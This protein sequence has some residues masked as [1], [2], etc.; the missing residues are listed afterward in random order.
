MAIETTPDRVASVLAQLR[1]AVQ[2]AAAQQLTVLHQARQEH[3]HS[4]LLLPPDLA[5]DVLAPGSA[6]LKQTIEE[7]ILQQYG[8][9]GPTEDDTAGPAEQTALRDIVQYDLLSLEGR[10]LVFSSRLNNLQTSSTLS[11]QDARDLYD[12]LDVILDLEMH[13]LTESSFALTVH[14]EI[15]ERLPVAACIQH[16]DYIESRVDAL[17]KGLVPSKGKGLV[18]LRFCNELLRRLSKPSSRHTVFAGRILSFLSSVFPLGERSGVNLRGDFNVDNR[19]LIDEDVAEGTTSS[20]EPQEAAATAESTSDSAEAERG[21]RRLRSREAA[22]QAQRDKDAHLLQSAKSTAFYRLFW[23]AQQWFANP[24]VLLNEKLAAQ[25]DITIPS[26]AV[27]PAPEGAKDGMKRFRTVTRYILDVFGAVQR[28]EKEL[29]GQASSEE[30]RSAFQGAKREAESQPL[31]GRDLDIVGRKRPRKETDAANGSAPPS[32]DGEDDAYFPKYLTGK[33]LIEYELRDASFRRQVLVQHLILYQYLLS[34]SA[35]GREKAKGWKNAALAHTVSYALDES[36]DRWLRD[37]WREILGL[38]RDTS[39]EGR[40]YTLAALQILKHEARWIGWK[41]DS[42]PPIDRPAMNDEQIKSFT[43]ARKIVSRPLR[44]YPFALGTAA[45]SRLWENGVRVPERTMR[46]ME[47]ASGMEIQVE[48]DGLDDLEM[49]PMIPSL[50]SYALQIKIIEDKQ[51][52][53]R[54]ELE[55][56]APRPFVITPIVPASVRQQERERTAREDK[57]PQI[58]DLERDRAVQAWRAMRMART[59]HLDLFG[60]VQCESTAPNGGVAV[61]MR[62][63]DVTRLMQSVEKQENGIPIVPS[64]LAPP[65]QHPKK[66]GDDGAGKTPKEEVVVEEKKKE[67]DG[68]V[69]ASPAAQGDAKLGTAIAEDAQ[70]AKPSDRAVEDAAAIGAA[71]A[72]QDVEMKGSAEDAHGHIRGSEAETEGEAAAEPSS[73]APTD[74]QIAT[75]GADV[76]MEEAQ[77][78]KDAHE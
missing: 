13:G 53:R 46:T 19:T 55:W 22:A 44:P 74:A 47:D 16:F 73:G 30:D 48:T 2:A 63:D 27:D 78:A 32:G 42:C 11:L 50:E 60:K 68:A 67:D 52:K 28:R 26:D 9:T 54:E 71:Q 3:S 25:T 15:L 61:G 12:R 8:S 14:Q 38:I 4:D 66:A 21:E 18:L 31:A 23:G 43:N 34:F 77:G 36:D 24:A 62:I 33:N 49:G 20:S 5:L 76:K 51:A 41:A 6:A 37:T 39:S 29:A 7:A 35:S 75:S 59:L 45:L 56:P 70:A 64:V 72:T 69:G 17:T 57:D 65:P 58:A 40:N 10:K 1:T